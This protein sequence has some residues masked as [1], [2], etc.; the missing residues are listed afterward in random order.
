MENILTKQVGGNHY[1]NLPYQPVTLFAKTRCTAFQANI[2]KYITRYPYKNGREDVEKAKHY[3]ELAIELG[4]KGNLSVAK[5]G[6]VVRFCNANALPVNQR[7]VVLEAAWD[8]YEKVIRN[9]EIILRN[10]FKADISK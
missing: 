1:K 8:N 6:E 7:A 2:W 9:C 4:C 10:E 3:A 5:R